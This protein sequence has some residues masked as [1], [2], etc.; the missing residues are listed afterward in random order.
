MRF[1]GCKYDQFRFKP[2]VNSDVNISVRIELNFIL[3]P[4]TKFKIE[5]KERFK[6][7]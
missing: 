7:K 4:N 2:E 3:P 1:V 5:L 6:K